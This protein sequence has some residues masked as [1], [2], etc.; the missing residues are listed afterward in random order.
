VL[1]IDP[2]RLDARVEIASTPRGEMP[3]IYGSIPTH[4]VVRRCSLAVFEA[5]RETLP[6]RIRDD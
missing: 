2:R 4:A 3:H 6:D 1:Q 5:G